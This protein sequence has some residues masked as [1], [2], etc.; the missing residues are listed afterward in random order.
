MNDIHIH[1]HKYHRKHF[2]I[3]T[4]IQHNRTKPNLTIHNRAYGVSVMEMAIGEPV[5]INDLQV[6]NFAH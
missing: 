5:S 3:L 6:N 1:Y 4:N 2:S